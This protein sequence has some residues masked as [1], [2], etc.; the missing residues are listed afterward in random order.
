MASYV[1]QGNDSDGISKDPNGD[2]GITFDGEVFK[3]HEGML[4]L[5]S[6]AK[7]K[8]QNTRILAIFVFFAAMAGWMQ[9]LPEFLTFAISAP[10]ALLVAL[11][12]VLKLGGKRLSAYYISFILPAIMKQCG[13][14]FDRVRT[15][16]LKSMRGNVLD[17]GSGGAEYLQYAV[18][19]SA[20]SVTK[21]VA[22]E[23]NVNHR[24]TIEAQVRKHKPDFPV[25]IVHQFVE[26]YQGKA[27]FDWII[28][29]N[30]LCEV[31]NPPAALRELDRLLK[32]GGRV[33]FSE[34]VREEDGTWAATLQ[35]WFKVPWEIV[36]DG[37]CCNR[38]TLEV[39]RSSVPNWT[40]RNWTFH[41]PVG[42]PILRRFEVGIAVKAE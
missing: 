17:F 30:V 3:V 22:M 10:I 9:K 19:V 14:S 7:L 18:K 26:D 42:P 31:P 36:S 37:C 1:R 35:D 24:K 5:P 40:L 4:K 20:G 28:L 33:Y 16:L 6:P 11:I 29:G 23:P 41:T 32:P 2:S 27:L 15:E 12:L 21:Y 13:K 39:I 34:H 25:D 38:R 8:A